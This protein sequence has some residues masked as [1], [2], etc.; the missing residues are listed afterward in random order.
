MQLR[1]A[2]VTAVLL[3][4]AGLAHGEDNG[5]RAVEVRKAVERSL[6]FLEEKGVAWIKQKGCVLP[7]VMG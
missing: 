1:I 2:C 5:P 6:P 4:G 7:G 3:A